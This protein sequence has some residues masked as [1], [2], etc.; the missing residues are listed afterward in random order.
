MRIEKDKQIA[1]LEKLIEDTKKKYVTWKPASK[2]YLILN[3][4]GRIP[5]DSEG[6][7]TCS[8]DSDKLKGIVFIATFSDGTPCF[9]A[10]TDYDTLQL[11]DVADDDIYILAKR[12]F[13]ILR[14]E[15]PAPSSFIDQ[16][17]SESF[18]AGAD[19]HH[20]D[21]SRLGMG[22]EQSH[23]LGT[24]YNDRHGPRGF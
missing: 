13:N 6:G 8:F 19:S 16:F 15:H 14:N 21:R 9:G 12:L 20:P 10:G 18:A 24:R 22:G 3:A 4:V 7:F 23:D 17:M 5:A 2:Q 11:F 1:F